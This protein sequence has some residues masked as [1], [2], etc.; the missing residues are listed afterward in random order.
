MDTADHEC[1]RMQVVR[2]AQGAVK[3]YLARPI[4]CRGHEDKKIILP[5]AK[6]EVEDATPGRGKNTKVL[7]LLCIRGTCAKHTLDRKA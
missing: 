6:H 2:V 4:V 7:G 3:R 5:N 1:K